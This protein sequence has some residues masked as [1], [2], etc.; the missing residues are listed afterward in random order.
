M[1]SI[2][3]TEEAIRKNLGKTEI[4]FQPLDVLTHQIVGL[5]LDKESISEDETFETVL[6]AF[7][8]R[9]L[10]KDEFREL[11]DFLESI[12]LVSKGGGIL[13]SRK[14]GRK[15]YYENLG[16]M[17]DER[18]YP[19]IDLVT[20]RIIGTVG[21]E[22]WALRARIGLNVILKGQVWRIIQMDEERGAIH[23]LPSDD[24]LGALP[25]WDG[26]LIPV[27]REVA[28]KVGDLR[29]EV[30]EE[31]VR[32]GSKERA[33]SEL[34]KRYQAETSAI[35]AIA[36]EIVNHLEK[37]FPIPHKNKILL[38]AYN[39]FLV[40]HSNFG[41]KI[42]RTFGA[43]FDEILS[44]L[45]LIYSWWNDPYRILIEA[46]R[47]IDRFDLEKIEKT[48]F[49]ISEEDAENLLDKFMEGRFPFGYNMKFIAE[50]FGVVPKG[51]TL[52]S[53]SLENLYLRF[54]DTPIYRETVR[55]AHHTKLDLKSV[56]D[57][58]KNIALGEIN[59]ESL[60]TKTPSPLAMHILEAYAD[61]E[62]LLEYKYS[63][64]EKLEHM[65]KSIDARW[66]NLVCMNCGDW[67]ARVKIKEICD[68]PSCPKCGSYSLPVLW[69][70]QN[71]EKFI[72]FLSKWKKDRQLTEEEFKSLTHGRKTADM[73]L[74]YGRK[75][76]IAF[77]VHGVG[78]VTAY[79]ILSRMHRNEKDFYRDLLKAK[80]QYFKT[81][82]YWREG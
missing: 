44:D 80:I 12:G 65:K 66:A 5:T 33:I 71:P 43:I 11:I 36:D 57:I 18:R 76:I 59:T 10:E 29:A 73:V 20:D 51:K 42:N 8:F 79:Q 75:A 37:G 82:H 16:M 39:K 74:S 64:T 81:R 30:A 47:K 23:V 58:I 77:T 13:R 70:K 27:P 21:D 78:P 31:I 38:E 24:P 25:G 9:N 62:E 54:R 28:E 50:R 1:E 14:R 63:T 19:F 46:P 35:Q 49:Q 45:D 22:F 32:L 48:L 55:E 56:K 61:V 2:V 34:S 26:E 60:V 52:N 69:K 53:K 41:E 15:Y 4:H 6:G 40:I 3:L 67:N 72:G 7:P 68:R 17:N